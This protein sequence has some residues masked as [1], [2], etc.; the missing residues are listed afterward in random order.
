[1]VFV[2]HDVPRATYDINQ[3]S[4]LQNILTDRGF[5]MAIQL[6]RRVRPHGLMFAGVP[7][8]TFVFMNLGTS[9]CEAQLP[10]QRGLFAFA[11]HA[12][13]PTRA[14]LHTRLS[15]MGACLSVWLHDHAH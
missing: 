15:N 7:C 13:L 10:E 3:D 8:S 6:I 12:L 4:E 11:C 5:L 1:M 14:S 9:Q 2:E